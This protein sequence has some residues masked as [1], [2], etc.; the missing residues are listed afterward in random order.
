MKV[1]LIFKK[2]D[3]NQSPEVITSHTDTMDLS[4]DEVSKLIESTLLGYTTQV[5]VGEWIDEM[6]DES[7]MSIID[8]AHTNLFGATA[9]GF[10][11][12]DNNDGIEIELDE[13]IIY[14]KKTIKL[15]DFFTNNED[16]F[17]ESDVEEKC[18]E[19]TEELAEELDLCD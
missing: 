15:H 14:G 13:V 16:D 6:E 4:S 19:Y 17:Y 1:E 3:Y 7:L 18:K 11:H 5:Q 9:D 10:Y 8:T 12:D 2:T